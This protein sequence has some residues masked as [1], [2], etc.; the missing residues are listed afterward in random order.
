MAWF[1]EIRDSK[2]A[3]VGAGK[4]FATHGAAMTAGRKKARELKASGSLPG[5]GVG[6]VRAEKNSEVLT[7]QDSTESGNP[8][9]QQCLSGCPRY[10][11]SSG[12]RANFSG[13]KRSRHCKRL[14]VLPKMSYEL[15]TVDAPLNRHRTRG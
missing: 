10:D 11:N 9:R 14:I 3:V 6:T 5:G 8:L 12:C 13:P 2:K 4:G 1:Y 15:G 7:E